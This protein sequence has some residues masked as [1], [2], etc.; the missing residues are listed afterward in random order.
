MKLEKTMVPCHS[1]QNRRERIM[2]SLSRRRL[3]SVYHRCLC[4]Y[5]K[6]LRLPNVVR[7]R[8]LRREIVTAEDA[9]Q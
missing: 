8:L 9:R 1:G 2:A 4:F 6:Q 5:Q 3:T 7:W